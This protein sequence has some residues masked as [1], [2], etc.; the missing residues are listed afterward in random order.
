MFSSL[1][2]LSTL[3]FRRRGGGGILFFS[4]NAPHLRRSL[5]LQPHGGPSRSRGSGAGGGGGG[6][7]GSSG[8]IPPYIYVGVGAT[9]LVCASCY[10]A[11]LDE[12]P[13][14]KRKRWIATSPEWERKLGDQE[15]QQLLASFRKQQGRGD[16]N[17]NIILPPNHRASVTVQ[18]VGSRIAQASLVL[19]KQYNLQYY[20]NSKIPYTYT[21]VRSD[22]ANA[23]VLPGNHVFVM[24]GLFRH[25]RNEDELA[26]VLGHEVAH[27]LARHAGEKVSSSVVMNILARLSLLLDPSGVVLALLLP[28][29]AL[30]RNLPNSRTQEME[31]DQIGIHLAAEACYDPRAAKTVFAAMKADADAATAGNRSPPEFLSTHPSHDSRISNFDAW[32]PEAMTRFEGDDGARCATVRRAMAQARAH[33]AMIHDDHRGGSGSS[34]DWHG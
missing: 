3:H 28:A 2:K 10:F 13:L 6:G 4:S 12:A 26:A 24:T 19:A 21:V 33:A 7:S 18:R 22:L 25:V 11:F 30:F 34:S 20:Y 32:L 23:F 29:A 17:N 8:N 31:A 9:T 14:T 1:G 16:N 5:Q 27:N 15:Y